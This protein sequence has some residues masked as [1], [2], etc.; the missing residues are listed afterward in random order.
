MMGKRAAQ[1]VAREERLTWDNL[2]AML[3]KAEG[4]TGQSTVNAAIALDVVRLIHLRAIADRDLAEAPKMW[5]RDIYSRVKPSR[6]FLSVTN[7]LRDFGP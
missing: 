1:A 6:D 3:D 4:C 5:S 7:I 2:K